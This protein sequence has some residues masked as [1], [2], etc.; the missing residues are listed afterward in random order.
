MILRVENLEGIDR[1]RAR[2]ARLVNPDAT[3]LSTIDQGT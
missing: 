2:F 3:P 1:L